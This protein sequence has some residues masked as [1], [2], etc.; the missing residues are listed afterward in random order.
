[1][2][3]CEKTEGLLNWNDLQT[4]SGK[5]IYNMMF[6][7]MIMLSLVCLVPVLWMFLSAFKN[8][9]NTKLKNDIQFKC[10]IITL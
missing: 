9:Y 5:M 7:L 2:K 8:P 10:C 4:S 6:I 3:R 1:M